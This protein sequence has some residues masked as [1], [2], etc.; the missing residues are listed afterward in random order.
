MIL[1]IAFKLSLS[2]VISL[3]LCFQGDATWNSEMRKDICYCWAKYHHIWTLLRSRDCCF[4]SG[5]FCTTW[6]DNALQFSLPWLS[7]WILFLLLLVWK[8]HARVFMHTY[9]RTSVCE[10]VCMQACSIHFML[11]VSVYRTLG[12]WSVCLEGKYAHKHHMELAGSGRWSRQPILKN[13]DHRNLWLE[14]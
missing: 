7:S 2:L 1:S 11:Q 9:T 14:N 8:A 13:Q 6:F 5:D 12:V 10:R 4:Y 3:K